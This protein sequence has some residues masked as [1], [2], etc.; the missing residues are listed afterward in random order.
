[1]TPDELSILQIREDFRNLMTPVLRY[2]VDSLGEEE[3]RDLLTM[4]LFELEESFGISPILSEKT[5]SMRA[6][7]L[8]NSLVDNTEE[9]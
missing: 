7:A 1:M 8:F 4:V 9:E 5:R 2:L 6:V 3:A